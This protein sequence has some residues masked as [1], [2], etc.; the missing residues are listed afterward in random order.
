[1]RRT[2]MLMVLVL[3]GCCSTYTAPP[4][5]AEHPASP[6][7]RSAEERKR[8]DTLGHAEPVEAPPAGHEGHGMAPHGGAHAAPAETPSAPAAVYTCPMHPEVTSDQPGRCPKC[9][10][11]LV[12][13]GG[14]R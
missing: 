14:E 10:M 9:G 1:M 4:L 11:K 8:P 6:D 2:L 12:K 5:T 7:A 3:S 13:K